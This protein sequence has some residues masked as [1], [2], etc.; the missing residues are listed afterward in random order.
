MQIQPV[1][2][3]LQMWELREP[4]FWV[5]FWTPVCFAQPGAVPGSKTPVAWASEAF[6]VEGAEAPEV[7]AW[8]MREA[9]P[10]RVFTLW[11][12]VDDPKNGL[13]LVR[14]AGVDPTVPAEAWPA[15]LRDS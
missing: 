4:T 3:R 6:E 13:G 15:N 8:A 1:D 10:D 2:E 14:L 9:T 11:V 5:L 7:L 12:R